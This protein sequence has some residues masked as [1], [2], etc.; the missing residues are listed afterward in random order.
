MIGRAF[1]HYE[2]LHGIPCAMILDSKTYYGA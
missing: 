2:V 1:S